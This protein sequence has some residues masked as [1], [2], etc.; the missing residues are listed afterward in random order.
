MK[1][2]EGIA[3]VTADSDNTPI[4]LAKKRPI[5]IYGQSSNLTEFQVRIVVNYDSDMILICGQ[6]L[7]T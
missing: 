3:Y 4:L 2:F 7:P 6:T 5:T 1:I